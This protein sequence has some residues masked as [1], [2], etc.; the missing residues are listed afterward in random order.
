MLIPMFLGMGV[1]EC[2]ICSEPLTEENYRYNMGAH[3]FTCSAECSM[4]LLTETFGPIGE[5][6]DKASRDLPEV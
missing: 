3:T 2:Q 6:H 4:K 1:E 5:E